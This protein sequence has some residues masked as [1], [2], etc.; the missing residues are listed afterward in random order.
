LI[1]A[2]TIFLSSFLLFLV[3]PLIARLILPWF[4]GS[5]AV[6]TTCMLCFQVK[7]LAGYAYAHVLAR[8]LAAS[9][10]ER[11]VHVLLLAAALALL[12]IAP[13]E[14]W[15]PLGNEE[16]ISRILL[17]LLVSV[18]L[19]YFLL[20]S[21]SPLLQAWFV[22]ER[23]GADP[24]RLFAVSNLASLLA[25]VGY[26]FVVEPFL[27]AHEQVRFWSWLFVA[28]AALCAV[29]AWRTPRGSSSAES[30]HR[31]PAPT[32]GRYVLWLALSATGS[33]LLLAVTNHLTQNVASVPLLWLAPLTLYLLTFIVTFEGRGWYQ[34]K[35]LWILVL[36]VFGLMAWAVLDQEHRYDLA[37]QLAIFLP[38]LFV[39][40][41]FCHGEL[42][43]SRPAPEHLTAFYLTV[44]A[45]GALGGFAVAVIAPLAFNGYYELGVGLTAAALLAA[46]RFM[47][48]GLVPTI[49][50]LGVLFGVGA[51]AAYDIFGQ[52]RDVLV[53]TRGFYGV[54]RVKEYGATGDEGH[55]RRL[56]H[57]TIMHG[58]QYLHDDRRRMLTTYYQETSGIGLAIASRQSHPV[59][60][61][62]IGLGTG[63]IAAYGRAGD[64]FRFYEIDPHVLEIARRDFTVLG[65]S[66][67]KIETAL[68]DARLSLE[69]EPPQGF[70]VLA[71]DA[72]SSDA[73]P[74]HLIT[75]EALGVFL[76]QVKPDG[77]VAFHVSNRFLDLIPVVARIAREQGAHAVL[78]RD[79]PDDEDDSTRSRTDWVLVSRD[80]KALQAE[81][82]VSGGGKPAEDRPEWRTWTDDYSNLVQI[83][84]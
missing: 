44:S 34:P 45:G 76:K 6:W 70:D 3:Q 12:P 18:G 63:T 26:P 82:I 5:A 56:V 29:L 55:L 13:G 65:D 4:G 22:R 9:N 46:L 10:L 57:G 32:R 49:L 25:L 48:L 1:H 74:V 8:R 47:P 77:I 73:I 79:D 19:P 81:K 38:G 62:V 75:K 7:L 16:P 84:K 54:L 80:E 83:L 43:R 36:A 23:P 52:Q 35:F 71:V 11:V 51:C 42:Y 39:A 24:Y 78:V 53:A 33:A 69:R 61:G 37:I 41:F 30:T 21:T 15:K 2:A 31:S 68:G 27:T 20:A 67:A 64:V 14:S 28:F 72:F 58:E 50:A 17:L 59:R 60:V 40:C 66:G